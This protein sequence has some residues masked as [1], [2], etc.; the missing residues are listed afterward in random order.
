MRSRKLDADTYVL[1]FE[2]GEDPVTGLTRFAGEQD[3]SACGFTAIGAFSEAELGYFDWEK[4]DYER[5]PVREQVE[6]L[7]LIG[8]IA[9]EKD[10]KK[11]H[12]HAVLGRRD[13]STRGGHLLSARVRPTLEV[14]LDVSPGR[15]RRV[16]DRE[17]GLALIK[18]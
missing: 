13:G 2:T 6:V 18:P 11:V 3:L 8:D 5:I 17:S 7:S 9:V 14:I 10:S 16:H 12:A 15:L 1:V 4:K